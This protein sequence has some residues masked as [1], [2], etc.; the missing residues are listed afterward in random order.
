LDG[1]RTRCPP[2]PSAARGGRSS[3]GA[4][5]LWRCLAAT[6]GALVA[7]DPHQQG[8]RPPSQRF[9]CEG[10]CDRAAGNAPGHHTNG[11][12][13]RDQRHGI[14]APHGRGRDTARRLRA[15]AHRAGRTKSGQ[16]Q[17]GSV[18]H[19]EVFRMGSVGTSIIGRPDRYPANDAHTPATPSNAM[20]RL[21]TQGQK[22]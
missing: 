21:R 8:R 13:R 3:P 17:E 16:G 2:T 1:T 6:P 20:S 9:V 14:P 22:C 15:R 5:R 18:G 11:T 10:P 4:A 19:G 7:A 12:S